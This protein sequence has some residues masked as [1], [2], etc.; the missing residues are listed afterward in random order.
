METAPTKATLS[1]NPSIPETDCFPFQG[2]RVNTIHCISLTVKSECSPG[3]PQIGEG[4]LFK[5]LVHNLFKLVAH[6]LKRFYMKAQTS[7]VFEQDSTP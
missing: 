2:K 7:Q 6:V 5:W 4:P 1:L 3:I